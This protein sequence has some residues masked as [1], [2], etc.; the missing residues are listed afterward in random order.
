MN[1]QSDISKRYK[2]ITIHCLKQTKQ[3]VF[4]IMDSDW[5]DWWKVY[6]AIPVMDSG[7]WLNC[8]LGTIETFAAAQ[9]Y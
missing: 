5:E 7:E 6:V 9:R 4:D 8:H 2:S 3:S 1:N